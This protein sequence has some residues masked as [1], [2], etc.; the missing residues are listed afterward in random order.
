MTALEAR[1]YLF[2]ESF[3]NFVY[4]LLYKSNLKEER[5]FRLPLLRSA[6]E[7]GMQPKDSLTI[8]L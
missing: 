7:A 8:I 6:E 5:I 2:F 1:S 3:L 4:S